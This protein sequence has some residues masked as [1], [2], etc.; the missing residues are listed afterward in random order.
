MLQT[1]HKPYSSALVISKTKASA[2]VIAALYFL[3][4]LQI[5]PEYIYSDQ[6]GYR[7][8]YEHVADYDIKDA[9][10][11]YQGMLGTSEPI[12]FLVVYFFA[13]WLDKDV[14]M[15]LL[16]AALIY[17]SVIWLRRNKV[18]WLVLALL[19]L[20]FYLMVLFFSAERLKLALLLLMLAVN[21]AGIKRS[22]FAGLAFLSHTQ[23]ALLTI[24]WI[25]LKAV[26]AVSSLLRGEL[27]KSSLKML[28]L[29]AGLVV[30]VAQMSGHLQHKFSAYAETSGGLVELLK[31]FLFVGL[32]LFYAR[33]E[34][35]NALVMHS[36][37]LLAAF[38][39]GG[40]RIV[41]FS[42]VI[43]LAYALRYR[44]GKNLGV[45]LTSAYFIYQGIDFLNKIIEHGNGF[46][47]I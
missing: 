27:R 18:S 16:N 12:Y 35:I 8:F 28:V 22:V 1:T 9:F 13:D 17:T 30:L 29:C 33:R 15:S 43:F 24:N 6:I 44:N 32:T 14:L 45:F 38:L 2:F 25:T 34:R 5:Y 3:F 23:T 37:L 7:L 20:N 26:P 10:L 4:S 40:N 31:P 11:L 21:S 19:S 47:G 41:I 39:I 42:Y 46:H 36:P